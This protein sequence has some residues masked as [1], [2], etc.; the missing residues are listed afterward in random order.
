MS[1]DFKL[2]VAFLFLFFVWMSAS[3]WPD[4]EISLRRAQAAKLG[5][6]GQSIWQCLSDAN[7]ASQ[8][9]GHP[10]I[11]PQGADADRSST[12][13]F[14]RAF[15]LHWLES[16][17]PLDLG[18]PGVPKPAGSEVAAFTATNNAWCVT[19]NCNAETPATTPFLF[20]RNFCRAP[21]PGRGQLPRYGDSLGD[22]ACLCPHTKPLGDTYGVIVTWGGSVRILAGK[23][24]ACRVGNRRYFN[25]GGLDLPFLHP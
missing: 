25:P 19:L 10:A 13:F 9:A 20:T 14:C 18:G 1:R 17:T 2:F 12:E 24:V 5:N 8:V 23:A 11:W 15:R 22:I 21:A 3:W 16:V 7:L 4:S 6:S